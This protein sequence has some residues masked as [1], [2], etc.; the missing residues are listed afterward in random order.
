MKEAE[1]LQTWSSFDYNYFLWAPP[2]GLMVKNLPA[3]AGN[4]GS[5]LGSGRSPWRRKWQP[6]GLQSVR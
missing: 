2:G 6:G 4:A 5:I 3:N 1:E